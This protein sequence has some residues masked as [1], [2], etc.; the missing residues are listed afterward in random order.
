[1]SIQTHQARHQVPAHH[2]R[3]RRPSAP[4]IR[5]PQHLRLRSLPPARRFSQRHSRRLPRRFPLASASRH[6]D[7]HLRPGRH[8]RARRQHRQQRRHRRRRHPVDDGRQRHHPPGNAQGR[9][10][11]PHAR[12]P[13]VGQPPR[14]TENDGPALPGSES[15]GNPRGHRRRRHPNPRHLRPLLGKKGSHRRH[16]RR[17]GLHRR[18]R[19]PPA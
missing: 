7:H 8:R 11:R 4:R 14:R 10:R 12:L 18:S 2:R 1:M 5:L 9:S 17:P 19:F 16:R 3:R 15:P 6:R 13:V